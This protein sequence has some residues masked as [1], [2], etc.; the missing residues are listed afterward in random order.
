M[1]TPRLILAAAAVAAVSGCSRSEQS[2][3]EV[4]ATNMP[5]P[6]NAMHNEMMANGMCNGGQCSNDMMANGM[7]ANGMM[8]GSSANTMGASSGMPAGNTAADEHVAHHENKT[9]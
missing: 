6:M 1:F 2:N 9:E 3:N 7:M 4:Q 5:A 8:G